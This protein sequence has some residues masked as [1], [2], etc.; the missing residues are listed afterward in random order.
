MP[1]WC[2]TK[3][4][5]VI[6]WN[7]RQYN[8]TCNNKCWCVGVC[9]HLGVV[10]YIHK[11]MLTMLFSKWPLLFAFLPLLPYP[12]DLHHL[13]PSISFFLSLK[14]K[15]HKSYSLTLFRWIVDY[16]CLNV[17]FPLRVVYFFVHCCKSFDCII[18]GYFFL[19]CFS[20]TYTPSNFHSWSSD[21]VQNSFFRS[22]LNL[23]VAV[24]HTK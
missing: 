15:S 21:S 19:L 3:W 18:M 10:S 1:F 16:L 11:A 23:F 17:L 14:N 12:S 6:A 7:G 22:Q 20:P 5:T 4:S 8:N 13:P 24:E 9:A 2:C